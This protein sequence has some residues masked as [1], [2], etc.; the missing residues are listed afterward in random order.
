MDL[1]VGKKEVSL[2]NNHRRTPTTPS[3][4]SSHSPNAQQQHAQQ[5]QIQ[6]AITSMGLSPFNMGSLLGMKHD[7]MAAAAA[8]QF[9]S[10]MTSAL[11]SGHQ[12][13]PRLLA[14][15]QGLTLNTKGNGH[16][17]GPSNPMNDLGHM[18]HMM[19]KEER[20]HRSLN[21]SGS[22]GPKDAGQTN[23]TSGTSNSSSGGANNRNKSGS[24]PPAVNK[25][26]WNPLPPN[27]AT[28]TTLVNPSTGKNGLS[29]YLYSSV[30]L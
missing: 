5:L 16:N 22:S 7:L 30:S 26:S 14:K 4:L 27:V 11:S 8:Q 2:E 12:L 6:N 17:N 29:F 19:M 18:G 9:L 24:S 3:G 1:T 28:T 15:E 13:P 23:G 10:T 20:T 25:R 21:Q